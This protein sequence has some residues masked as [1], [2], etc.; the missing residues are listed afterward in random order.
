ME[1]SFILREEDLVNTV[2]LLI[3]PEIT[4]L[5]DSNFSGVVY[6]REIYTLS[7][8]V[9]DKAGVVIHPA[10]VPF[11]EMKQIG[12]IPGTLSPSKRAE[13]IVE[14]WKTYVDERDKGI[15]QLQ[16]KKRD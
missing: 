6:A 8:D 7:Q 13:W 16:S 12:K 15:Q 9:K 1:L 10:N 11:S 5:L 14:A 4:I 3:I 2:S